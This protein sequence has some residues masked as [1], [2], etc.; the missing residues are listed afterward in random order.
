MQKYVPKEGHPTLRFE[1]DLLDKLLQQAEQSND[2]ILKSTILEHRESMESRKWAHDKLTGNSDSLDN[3]VPAILGALDEADE[4]DE[5]SVETPG[6]SEY[7]EEQEPSIE[8]V[9]ETSDSVEPTVTIIPHPD[10]TTTSDVPPPPSARPS[11][12]APAPAPAPTNTISGTAN[13]TNGEQMIVHSSTDEEVTHPSNSVTLPLQEENIDMTLSDESI[14]SLF[15]Q[16]KS[17]SNDQQ[18]KTYSEMSELFDSHVNIQ[19]PP[20]A[21]APP[22]PAPA[23]TPVSIPSQSLVRPSTEQPKLVKK[24]NTNIQ[25][26]FKRLPALKNS[27]LR[28]PVAPSTPLDY[29]APNEPLSSLE[30]IL[31]D[32]N[33][34]FTSSPRTSTRHMAF[35]Q[36][37]ARLYAE[38]RLHR[39][40]RL[41]NAEH[42][43]DKWV[44]IIKASDFEYD[45]HA[46]EP[47][48]AIYYC[49]AYTGFTAE[50]SREPHGKTGPIEAFLDPYALM[51]NFE[52]SDIS[53]HL[54]IKD[55]WISVLSVGRTHPYG[56]WNMYNMI[57][58]DRKP[59]GANLVYWPEYQPKDAYEVLVNL[60]SSSQ[61]VMPSPP[62][63]KVVTAATSSSKKPK[64]VDSNTT[65]STSTAATVT[66]PKS[67]AT[68]AQVKQIRDTLETHSVNRV[69]V[70]PA[71]K[72]FTPKTPTSVPKVTTITNTPKRKMIEIDDDSNVSSI[73]VADAEKEDYESLKKKLKIA[74]KQLVESKQQIEQLQKE[75]KEKTAK[76]ERIRKEF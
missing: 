69:V 25:L 19:T 23:S 27:M 50:I 28:Y 63:S 12:P 10:V 49:V 51:K 30:D 67:K 20:P 26:D 35:Q 52:E 54:N 7:D 13:S 45:E 76:L 21:H 33:I 56:F 6:K 11:S 1:P 59:T 42:N 9:V 48:C 18:E 55:D 39:Y 58:Y 29:Q 36:S 72:K 34:V 71:W 46:G 64:N 8:E 62:R 37:C 75:N 61:T 74:E 31:D 43:V 68:A 44:V 66:K 15:L 38:G 60:P 47:N 65:T 4:D 41:F 32:G 24:T 57:Y 40:W 2:S 5:P 53:T 3:H 16:K 73:A 22:A 14:H 70:P 17:P